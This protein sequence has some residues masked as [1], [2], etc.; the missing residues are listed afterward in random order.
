MIYYKNVARNW[1]RGGICYRTDIE[2]TLGWLD[3]DSA[4]CILLRI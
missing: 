1:G 4:S 2:V 3:R